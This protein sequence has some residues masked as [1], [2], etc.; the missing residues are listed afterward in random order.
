MAA[1][2]YWMGLVKDRD[3][4]VNP[5]QVEITDP[6]HITEQ[7]KAKTLELGADVVGCCALTPIMI[8]EG[9]DMP[10]PQRRLFH[11]PRRLR[12]GTPGI[13]RH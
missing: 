12:Q 9:F 3:G 1:N 6:S 11:C 8:D 7:I 13:T 4:P 5:E 2:D 10:P